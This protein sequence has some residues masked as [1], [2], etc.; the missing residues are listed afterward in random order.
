MTQD[1]HLSAAIAAAHMIDYSGLNNNADKLRICCDLLTNDPDMRL[2]VVASQLFEPLAEDNFVR[3]HRENALN[4]ATRFDEQGDPLWRRDGAKTLVMASVL[5][6]Q[7]KVTVGQSVFASLYPEASASDYAGL[8]EKIIAG[9][10][11]MSE[12]QNGY[13]LGVRRIDEGFV[14]T[15]QD[16][17]LEDNSKVE[18]AYCSLATGTGNSATRTDALLRAVTYDAVLLPAVLRGDDVIN[19]VTEAANTLLPPIDRQLP[20]PMRALQKPTMVAAVLAAG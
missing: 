10:G 14:R 3:R 4:I 8:F 13:S 11:A 7:N 1:T 5:M 6:R 2:A 17:I 16:A 18:K 19:L 15:I 20:A 9:Y 12:K